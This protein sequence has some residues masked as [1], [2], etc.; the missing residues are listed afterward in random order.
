MTTHRPALPRHTMPLVQNDSV[1]NGPLQNGPAQ[2]GPAVSEPGREGGP[3]TGLRGLIV[4]WG[5]V[6]TAP[7]D[8]AMH[9]WARHEA[10][11]IEVFRDVMHG[12]LGQPA[13]QLVGIPTEAS[14][15][16]EE[17]PVTPPVLSSPVHDL[18][19]GLIT[20]ESFE[21]ALAAALGE[22]GVAINS[23]GLLS[24]VLAGLA[25]L[26]QDMLSLVRRARRGGIR[27]ALLSNSWGEHYPEHQ[28]AGAFDAVV[29]S[30]RVGMRKPDREIFQHTADLLNLPTA[31]CVMVD[32]LPRN[33]EAAVA[34]GMVGVLHR[35]YEQTAAELDIL[36]ELPTS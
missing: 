21:I 29:I 5:G 4:D 34:A 6:L 20:P 26:E 19:K 22:R 16:P 9:S 28:W 13:A 2:T 17:P 32:D 30:G 18:E 8:E 3:G 25:E 27:T 15:G 33:I 10:V 7:L 14:S 23:A 24:R 12:W 31:E 35:T 1:E 36:L 11:P